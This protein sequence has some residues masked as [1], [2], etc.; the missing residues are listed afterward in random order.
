[1][2]VATEDWKLM[3]IS[4]LGVLLLTPLAVLW[5][6]SLEH[7]SVTRLALSIVVR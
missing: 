4:C 7:K 1:V 5:F 2:K 6:L 3:F